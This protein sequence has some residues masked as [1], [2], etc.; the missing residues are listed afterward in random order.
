MEFKNQNSTTQITAN[1][2]FTLTPS[3]EIS[4]YRELSDIPTQNMDVIEMIH[5]QFAQIQRMHLAKKFVALEIQ[6]FLK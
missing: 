3:L 4:V 5:A 2:L 6:S 1:D